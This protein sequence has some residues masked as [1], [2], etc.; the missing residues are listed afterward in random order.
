MTP[1]ETV[2]VERTGPVTIVTI[3]RP[4]AYNALNAEV[5]SR[6]RAAVLDADADPA[7]RAV[8][9]TGSGEKAFCA[10]ADLKELA[11]MSADRAHETLRTGQRVLRDIERAT[12]PVIA[13]VNGV[14]LGGG[15]EFVLAS[16]FP[17]LST[18]ASL[19]L[20]ESGL[21]LTPGYGGTQRLPRVIG[22]PAAAHLMLTGARLDAQRAHQLG[23]TPI[24]PVAPADLM[25]TA[26][27]LAEKIAAQGPIAVRSILTALECGRDAGLDAGLQMET[28]LA[29][30]AVA[31][32]ESD[33]GITAFLERRPPRFTGPASPPG[34]SA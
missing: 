18:G 24:P 21:G 12:V 9:V 20:P 26:T 2:L 32:A 14:A 19:G 23:L 3:N 8:V 25:A 11:G 15:F 1:S 34:E 4:E 28:G 5:L 6:L 27:A 16:T 30:L 29:A 22:A 10:G 7:V 33:E 31:G 17:V 13:A